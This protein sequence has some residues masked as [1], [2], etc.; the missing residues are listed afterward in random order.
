[1]G[2]LGYGDLENSLFPIGYI[3]RDFVLLVHQI[4]EFQNLQGFFQGLLTGL[5]MRNDFQQAVAM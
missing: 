5:F 2:R 4:N 3:S 1:M